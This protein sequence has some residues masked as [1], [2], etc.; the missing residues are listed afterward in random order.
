MA[1]DRYLPQV[2]PGWVRSLAPGL[3]HPPPGEV[4]LDPMPSGTL[5]ALTDHAGWAVPPDSLKL[6]FGRRERDVHLPIG[7]DDPRISR[8]H[9]YLHWAGDTWWIR[10]EGSPIMILFPEH[11]SLGQA[12]DPASNESVRGT[13]GWIHPHRSLPLAS[14]R[15]DRAPRH[16]RLQEPRHRRPQDPRR[17]QHRQDHQ[18]NQGRPGTSPT[19][20]AHQRPT[21]TSRSLQKPLLGRVLAPRTDSVCT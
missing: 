9:G 16:G 21:E 15:R 5:Y 13:V 7:T 1:S 20:S 10:N 4:P 17:D 18:G 8:F 2:L 6:E 19:D 12:W 14:S 11:V 3:P